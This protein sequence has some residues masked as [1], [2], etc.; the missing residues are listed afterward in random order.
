[1]LIRDAG[2]HVHSLQAMYT[3]CNMQLRVTQTRKKGFTTTTVTFSG[4]VRLNT[5]VR[6][7]LCRI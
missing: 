1:M 7:R 6:I 3:Q 4:D 5:R 2:M